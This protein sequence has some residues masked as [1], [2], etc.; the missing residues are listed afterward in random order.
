M[1]LAG[2]GA[3]H[4]DM[5]IRIAEANLGLLDHWIE[6]AH[7]V[8]PDGA[9]TSFTVSFGGPTDGLTL[10]TVIFNHGELMFR[11]TESGP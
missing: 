1:A 5:I 6:G 10:D 3:G 9:R 4:I 11:D 7:H 2:E 8:A